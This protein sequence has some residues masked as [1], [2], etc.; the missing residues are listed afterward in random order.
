MQFAWDSVSHWSGA[1]ESRERAHEPQESQYLTS[2]STHTS[3]IGW[4]SISHVGGHRTL[5]LSTN[6]LQIPNKTS[7]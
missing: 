3:I 2:M 1:K 7:P 6:A 5:P 4:A